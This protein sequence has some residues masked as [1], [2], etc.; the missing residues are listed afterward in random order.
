MTVTLLAEAPP[1]D[2]LAVRYTE[3]NT[4]LDIT[5]PL[6]GLSEGI[7]GTLFVCESQLYFYSE[8]QKSGIA[9]EYPDIIIHAISRQSNQPCIYAQLDQGIFFPNQQLPENEEERQE[10][11]T[12]IR[13]IP[14][15]SGALEAI[16]M[17]LS[18]CAALHPD[19][20]FMAEQEAYDDEFFADPSDEAELNEV[21]QAALRHL[22][23]VFEQPTRN[24]VAPH[25]NS[26]FDNAMDED[27]HQ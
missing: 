4:V 17:A 14:Q 19:E 20:E 13:F 24:G 27:Q 16:Y 2:D 7:S 9:V 8:D 10:T 15:D 25:E 6:V 21:Q 11:V 23:S 22:E 12:E 3:H 1:L 5:P 18:D 26:Q